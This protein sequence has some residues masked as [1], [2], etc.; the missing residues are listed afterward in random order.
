MLSHAKIQNN[1]KKAT[2]R[3]T[4]HTLLPQNYLYE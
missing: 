3:M 1:F 4:Y 2:L